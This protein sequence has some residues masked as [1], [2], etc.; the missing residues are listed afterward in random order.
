MVAVDKTGEGEDRHVQTFN[1]ETYL[2]ILAPSFRF[3]LI[4]LRWYEKT[5]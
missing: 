4:A 5:S 2:I 1:Q 3:A